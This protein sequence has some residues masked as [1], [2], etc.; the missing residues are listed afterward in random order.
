MDPVAVSASQVEE[1][2]SFLARGRDVFTRSRDD[3]RMHSNGM[4]R[5]VVAE[6]QHHSSAVRRH[7]R[8]G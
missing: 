3:G 8:A 6:A 5:F 1:A 2:N 7:N 4:Q